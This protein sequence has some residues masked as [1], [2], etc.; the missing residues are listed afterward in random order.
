VTI[1]QSIHVALDANFKLSHLRDRGGLSGIDR[2]GISES[3]FYVPSL[4]LIDS[5]DKSVIESKSS[6]SNFKAV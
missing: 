6:C 5:S 4:N 2:I 3:K 1:K